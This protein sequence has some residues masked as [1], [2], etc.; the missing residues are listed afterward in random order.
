MALAAQDHSALPEEVLTQEGP[1]VDEGIFEVLGAETEESEAE[2]SEHGGHESPTVLEVGKVRVLHHGGE[3]ALTHAIEHAG[4][5]ALEH[6][7][8]RGIEHAAGEVLAHGASHLKWRVAAV[9]APGVGARA[10][11]YL[12]YESFELAL[13][14][15]ERGHVGATI[16]YSL[17]GVVDGTTAAVNAVGATGLATFGAWL[18]N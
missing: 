18:D 13:E 15:G 9:A 5:R 11:S 1:G 14:A 4:E 7:A 2:H 17:A 10:A 8:E 12:A 6:A 3:H 16:A